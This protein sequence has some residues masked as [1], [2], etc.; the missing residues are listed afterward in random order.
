M[1]LST[2][3][4]PFK[5]LGG[6]GGFYRAA[7][8]LSVVNLDDKSLDSDH[9][10]TDVRRLSEKDSIFTEIEG[11]GSNDNQSRLSISKM[12]NVSAS[13]GLSRMLSANF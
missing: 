10:D 11:S 4:D 7:Q 5:A 12:S 6:A 3:P 1:S 9:S 13:K 8:R 2:R